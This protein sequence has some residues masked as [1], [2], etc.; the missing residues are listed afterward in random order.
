MDITRQNL[1]NDFTIAMKARLGTHCCKRSSRKTCCIFM[2]RLHR[3]AKRVAPVI[4]GIIKY[5]ISKGARAVILAIVNAVVYVNCW[6]KSLGIYNSNT[7]MRDTGEIINISSA[8]MVFR[9]NIKNARFLLDNLIV[10]LKLPL[11]AIKV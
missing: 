6:R 3:L 9:V 11:R 7:R 5:I 4:K 8:K 10:F 2:R 1:K